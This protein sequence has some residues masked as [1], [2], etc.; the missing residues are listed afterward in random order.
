MCEFLMHCSFVIL[1]F[2]Q[3]QVHLQLRNCVVSDPLL[4]VICSCGLGTKPLIH[5]EEEGSGHSPAYELSP[6]GSVIL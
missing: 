2:S 1:L 5:R 3:D 6:G 4:R